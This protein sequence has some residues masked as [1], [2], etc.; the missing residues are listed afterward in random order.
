[1]KARNIIIFLIIIV[2]LGLSIFMAFN[3]LRIGKYE[4]KP[5]KKLIRQG[6]DLKGGVY[7]VYEAQ[8]NKTGRELDELIEQVIG[9]FGRRV[10]SMG[11]TEPSITRE[12]GKRIRVELPGVKNA[13]EAI[14]MIG[15][16]AQLQFVTPDGEIVVTGANVVKSQATLGQ[17]NVASSKLC[18]LIKKG[19]KI[20]RS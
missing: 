3:G 12:G 6:L 5:M 13:Q 2:V 1:M 14:D 18:N 19:L 16:T 7:V 4:I 17:G 9:V 20:C 10:D 8:T 11:L 15:K